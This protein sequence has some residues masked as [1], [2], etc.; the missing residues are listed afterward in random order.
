MQKCQIKMKIS[1]KLHPEKKKP[2]VHWKGVKPQ[3]NKLNWINSNKFHKSDRSFEEFMI[4]E[5]LIF[6]FSQR[7][8]IQESERM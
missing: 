2:T 6:H 5:N 4:I 8:E 7:R 3:S 1:L